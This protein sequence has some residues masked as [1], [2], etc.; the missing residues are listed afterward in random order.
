MHTARLPHYPGGTF[1]RGLQPGELQDLGNE[2]VPSLNSLGQKW[3][4]C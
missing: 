1:L 3:F 4:R 2:Q